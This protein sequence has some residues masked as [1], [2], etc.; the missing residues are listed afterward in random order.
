MERGFRREANRRRIRR[1][2]M[3]KKN[4][5]RLLAFVMA[6]SLT[7]TSAPASLLSGTETVYAATEPK[8]VTSDFDIT[9]FSISVNSATTKLDYNSGLASKKYLLVSK[10]AVDSEGY[11]VTAGD[12]SWTTAESSG[13]T[14]LPDASKAESGQAS[15]VTTLTANT[16]YYVYRKDSSDNISEP[17]TI[18]TGKIALSLSGVLESVKL[19]GTEW[20]TTG[21]EAVTKTYNGKEQ[22][23]AVTSIT[24][25]A[26]G[27][28]TVNDEL[29]GSALNSFT[30]T[31]SDNINAGTAKLVIEAKEDSDYDG[32]LE[33]T[34]KIDPLALTEKN[35]RV[36]IGGEVSRKDNVYYTTFDGLQKN[37]EIK[38]E[39]KLDE[40]DDNSWVTL[41]RDTDYEVSYY[42]N[43]NTNAGDTKNVDAGDVTV[44]ITPAGNYKLALGSTVPNYGFTIKQANP[45]APSA[46]VVTDTTDA[47]I[48][49]D[50]SSENLQMTYQY[51]VS[52]TN[53]A[54]KID[55]AGSGV[56]T[57]DLRNTTTLASKDNEKQTVTL[58]TL[59]DGTALKA[60]TTYYVFSKIK[61]DSNVV[62]SK[63]STS[64]AATTKGPALISVLTNVKG[65]KI[66]E[67]VDFNSDDSDKRGNS[68][69]DTAYQTTL[70]SNYFKSLTKEYDGKEVD[71]SKINVVLEY[72]NAAGSQA[73]Y[74]DYTLKTVNDDST[75]KNSDVGK[76]W[77]VAVSGNNGYSGEVIVGYFNITPKKAVGKVSIVDRE[78]DGSTDVALTAD[79]SAAGLVSGDSINVTGLYGVVDQKNVGDV[80]LTSTEPTYGKGGSTTASSVYV[81]GTNWY[82]YTI[83][84]DLTNVT[85]K[86]TKA[87]ATIT[88]PETVYLESFQSVDL[89]QIVSSNIGSEANLGFTL[90]LNDNSGSKYNDI[91]TCTQAG[92]LGFKTGKGYADVQNAGDI[93]V[94]VK[95]MADATSNFTVTNRTKTIKIVPIKAQPHVTFKYATGSAPAS[96]QTTSPWRNLLDNRVTSWSNG[97]TLS[98][99]SGTRPEVI[100]KYVENLSSG[101]EVYT[102]ATVTALT[103][104]GH[105]AISASNTAPTADSVFKTSSGL[106]TTLRYEYYDST[107]KK[108]YKNQIPSQDGT[109]TVKV[110]VDAALNQGTTG[111]T[112]D[113]IDNDAVA[114]TLTLYIGGSSTKLPADNTTTEGTGEYYIE[115]G[116]IYE[117]NADLVRSQ[118][119]VIDGVTYYANKN[120][121]M[122]HGKTFKAADGNWHYA[123]EDG[124]VE[125]TKGI[126][127]T[128]DNGKVYCTGTSNGKLLV[129]GSKVVDGER[130]VANTKGKLV[131]NGFFTTAK[132]YK[133]CLKNYKAIKNKVFTYTDGYSYVANKNGTIQKGK[134]IV[135]L[136]GKKYYVNAGGSIAKN[137][138]VT[139]NGKKYVAQKSGVIA[140]SKKVTIGKKTYT[141]N[142]KGVITK[143]TTK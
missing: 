93:I 41:T 7:L 114:A 129:N 123:H 10:S 135:S 18:T 6:A 19:E 58:T 95:I 143:T 133:Y 48:T 136:N 17:V 99:P 101:N 21:S 36:T 141:T 25:D 73:T 86:I 11:V 40:D 50:V 83:S 14:E 94:T 110:Y 100:Q 106:S 34:F 38:V 49:V 59:Y 3:K 92:V 124:S 67:T 87:D 66:G 74:G 64:T 28:G 103:A 8:M 119:V 121:V 53:D 57:S 2:I 33:V 39:A 42:A 63:V 98:V 142:S 140:I 61:G 5:L 82:N 131:K 115:D 68:V 4:V 75:K 69:T 52:A 22:K 112:A 37:P 72:T 104:D 16:K 76:I 102:Y 134:K 111:Y 1:I 30:Y 139:Y 77:V 116:K 109:Y 120:G 70:K 13:A 9:T 44:Y 138:V 79:F 23:P 12:E 26:D 31:Y 89:G 20:G 137:K 107:G 96:A 78:Y 80:K 55:W 126:K 81:S 43:S 108:L 84:Y 60:Q 91:I 88:A 90:N 56:V 35:S 65:G 15:A 47:S 122:V 125:T 45:S 117:F 130:Y 27:D 46:P 132:G 29:A 85:G 24:V 71:V 105:A 128:D 32:K 113:N 51:A 54:S 97:Y 118:F 62:A 127:D